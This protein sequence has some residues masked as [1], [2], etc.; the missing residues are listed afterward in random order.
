MSCRCVDP[1]LLQR[2]VLIVTSKDAIRY[3]AMGSGML[4]S[5]SCL[6]LSQKSDRPCAA[7]V[8]KGCEC[9]ERACKTCSRDGKGSECTHRKP[10]IPDAGGM[11]YSDCFDIL[12]ANF[13]RRNV[14]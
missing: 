11:C 5:N 4:Q 13:E 9:I 2:I 6:M 3:D 1:F 14:T 12:F 10:A 7:C 8:R